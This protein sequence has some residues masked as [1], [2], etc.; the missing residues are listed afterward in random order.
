MFLII[1]RIYLVLKIIYTVGPIQTY[2]IYENTHISV[3]LLWQIL[4][5]Y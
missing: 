1:T 4:L 2:F 5:S 3:K